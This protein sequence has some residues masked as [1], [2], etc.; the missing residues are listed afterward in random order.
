LRPDNHGAQDTGAVLSGHRDVDG[1]TTTTGDD[2]SDARHVVASV[3]R[4][5]MVAYIG[6]EPGMEIHRRFGRLHA[7]VRQVAERIARE[8]V[9]CSTESGRQQREIAAYANAPFVDVHRGNSRVTA[10]GLVSDVRVHPV[11]NGLDTRPCRRCIAEQLPG[12]RYE[13]VGL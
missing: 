13:Q 10:A 5:P 9:D 4:V 1:V 2:A 6:F 7:D 8:N 3:E 11:A 12:Y